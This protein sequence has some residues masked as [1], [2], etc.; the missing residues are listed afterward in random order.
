MQTRLFS[1]LFLSLV[2]LLGGISLPNEADA[3]YPSRRARAKARHSRP[4]LR[5]K[6]RRVI[7]RTNRAIV[8][9]QDAVKKGNVQ[10]G[11][12]A[13]S[14]HHQ[15]FARR[16][17]RRGFYHRAINHSRRARTL[18]F[19]AIKANKG[20][21]PKELAFDGEEG[22]EGNVSDA[23]LDAAVQKEEPNAPQSDADVLDEPQE[24]VPE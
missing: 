7:R 5:T 18:A 16:M 1:F 3:Q 6:A 21:V 17:Y 4:V 22:P 13:K 12:L 24:D 14:V 10:T 11:N 2:V 19:A 20:N 8:L 9:A 15:R 23:E